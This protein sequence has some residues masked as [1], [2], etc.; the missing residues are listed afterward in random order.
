MCTDKILQEIDDWPR[1]PRD[2]IYRVIFMMLSLL[3]T[4]I[5]GKI[6]PQRLM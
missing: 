4:E 1:A 5:Y 3:S 2:E 6:T